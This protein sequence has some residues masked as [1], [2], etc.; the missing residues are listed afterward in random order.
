M[1]EY[2]AEWLSVW[3]D[4]SLALMK[5]T[6]LS[7]FKSQTWLMWQVAVLLH[8]EQLHLHPQAKPLI[9]TDHISTDVV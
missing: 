4:Y 3:M 6:T 5:K 9:S 8:K 1:S 2:V 7:L